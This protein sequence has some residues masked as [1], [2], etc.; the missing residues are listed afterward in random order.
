MKD[1]F[2]TKPYSIAIVAMGYTRAN[3]QN[4]LMSFSV[5]KNAGVDEIW[6]CN[7][8]ALM[9]DKNYIDKIWIM[10]DWK[11]M[12]KPILSK[13]QKRI[14]FG[15]DRPIITCKKYKEIPNCYEY[16]LAKVLLDVGLGSPP[17]TT[18]AYALMYAIHKRIP[19]I[20]LYG[21]DFE[22][23]NISGDLATFIKKTDTEMY[24]RGRANLGFWIGVA[25]G[26]GLRVFLPDNS[27][28]IGM[29]EFKNNP[30]LYGYPSDFNA[31]QFLDNLTAKAIKKEKKN[32]P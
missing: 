16:P 23:S 15:K 19:H 29:Q 11:E 25:N 26:L 18:S 22:H 20:H 8:T 6:A 4:Q 13:Y 21:T 14:L 7:L 2:K 28:V 9:L 32:G 27:N 31:A 10:D 5:D 3:F 17:Q 12:V 24:V 1:P 30:V